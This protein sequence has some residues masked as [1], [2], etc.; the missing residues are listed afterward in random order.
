MNALIHEY[1]GAM[2]PQSQNFGDRNL[3]V[4]GIQWGVDG[5]GRWS[6]RRA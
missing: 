3:R 2:Y 6:A 4:I 5:S 1:S